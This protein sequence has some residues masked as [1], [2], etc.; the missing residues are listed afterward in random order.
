MKLSDTVRRGLKSRVWL[1]QMGVFGICRHSPDLRLTHSRPE[2]L[3]GLR[4]LNVEDLPWSMLEWASGLAWVASLGHCWRVVSTT[5]ITP[6][7][8]ACPCQ[9]EPPLF[10]KANTSLSGPF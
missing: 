9:P 6:P 4:E 7:N 2:S 8:P 3:L 1:G 10:F 5:P